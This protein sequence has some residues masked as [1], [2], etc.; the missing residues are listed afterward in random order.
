[1]KAF[2]TSIHNSVTSHF[3]VLIWSYLFNDEKKLLP[4]L[5]LKNSALTLTFHHRLWTKQL[6]KP[7]ARAAAAYSFNDHCL[8]V[9]QSSL[10]D[11]LRPTKKN[12]PPVNLACDRYIPSAQI[13]ASFFFFHRK[14]SFVLSIL[15]HNNHLCRSFMLQQFFRKGNPS[16]KKT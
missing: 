14:P 11:L 9:P 16:S 15:T 12:M 8:H 1:M 6:K 7:I 5:L 3:F 2:I 13:Q 10:M 4:S